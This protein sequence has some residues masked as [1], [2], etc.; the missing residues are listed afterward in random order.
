MGTFNVRLEDKVY[1]RVV[2]DR[3]SSDTAAHAETAAVAAPG[4]TADVGSYQ[5]T[6]VVDADAVATPVGNDVNGGPLP[7]VSLPL[8]PN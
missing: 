7:N 1:G 6:G 2:L 5:A 8:N 3:V 4:V